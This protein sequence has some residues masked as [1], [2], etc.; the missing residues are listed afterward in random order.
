M[1]PN[2]HCLAIGA[3][4]VGKGDESSHSGIESI[5]KKPS[6]DQH[7]VAES[8]SRHTNSRDSLPKPSLTARLLDYGH[9]VT[10]TVWSK[11]D[12]KELIDLNFLETVAFLAEHT[13][14]PKDTYGFNWRRGF[15]WWNA[16]NLLP[17]GVFC[18]ELDNALSRL[19]YVPRYSAKSRGYYLHKDYS[20]H[21]VYCIG[22][23][24]GSLHSLC[25]IFLDLE[26]RGAFSASS[27]KLNS[28]CAV[29]C[30]GDLLDRSPYTLECM[31]LMLRLQREN[32]NQ[33]V[34][35]CGNHEHA[36]N[37]WVQPDG[38]QNEIDGDYGVEGVANGKGTCGSEDMGDKL[39]RFTRQLPLSAIIKTAIGTVQ[40]NHGSFENL[41]GTTTTVREEFL[42]FINGNGGSTIATLELVGGE[43]S[44]AAANPLHWG[45]LTTTHYN[46]NSE[47]DT[48]RRE[49]TA[50]MLKSYLDK[51]GLR[52]IIRGHS[53]LANLSLVYPENVEPSEELQNENKPADDAQILPWKWQLEDNRAPEE[54]TPGNR[55]SL[56]GK[57]Y[58]FAGYDM[59][60]L[61]VA[62]QGKD[63]IKSLIKPTKPGQDPDNTELL[64]VTLSSCPF[65]K[66]LP[67]I[68]M[69]TS[70]AVIGA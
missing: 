13:K 8:D 21:F 40:F 15:E 18:T 43:G 28:N 2:L 48:G 36:R 39:H 16:T 62:N 26:R 59:W 68:Q 22:D 32:P 49:S 33:V 24:H 17:R 51:T 1:L 4:K 11:G 63:F 3:K 66:S 42:N 60:S 34:L 65:S 29:V 58:V 41:D 64:A 57:A 9:H 44:Y 27:G 6:G 55:F 23:T 53:D 7:R 30:T 50:S 14:Y 54:I 47:R 31:Y 10:D 61:H 70:Y 12:E 38:S 67:P 35:T 19:A 69:M 52:M 56:N 5:I 46:S 25:D 37:Q 20:K 45:D